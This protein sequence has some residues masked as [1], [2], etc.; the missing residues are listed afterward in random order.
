MNDRTVIGAGTWTA[1][2]RASFKRQVVWPAAGR[3]LRTP[4]WDAALVGYAVVASAGSRPGSRTDAAPLSLRWIDPDRSIYDALPPTPERPRIGCVEGG[5]WDLID[6]RFADRAVPQAIDLR[7]REGYEWAETPLPAHVRDQVE[8]FGDAWGH[9]ED[10]VERRCRA[11][12]ELYESM[13]TDGY[14]TQATL[15]ARGT[16]GPGPP[17]VP[18][19]GEITVDVG[20]DGRLCWRRNGQHRLAIARVLGIERVPVLI[21]RRHAAWQAIRDRI[22]EDG[23]MVIEPTLRGHPDLADLCGSGRIDVA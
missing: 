22:R 16:S 5:D 7:F 9:V 13:R 20:R 15:A 23:T 3:L 18:T 11:I 14:L 8:R 2:A 6:D 21:A 1:R 19:L 12:E 17:P 10:A 4:V